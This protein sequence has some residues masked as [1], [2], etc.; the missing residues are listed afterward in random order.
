MELK[1]DFLSIFWSFPPL[2][3]LKSGF[4]IS[5]RPLEWFFDLLWAVGGGLMRFD[6]VLKWSG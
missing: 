6:E 3:E 2:V 1:S 4:L 5:C